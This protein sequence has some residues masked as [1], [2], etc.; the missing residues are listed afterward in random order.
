MSE[1]KIDIDMNLFKISGKTRK[2]R[3]G[4][5]KEG[6]IKVK[7]PSERKKIETLKKRSI[8]KMIREH[9]EDRYKK[10]FEDKKEEPKLQSDNSFNKDFKEAQNFFQ[11]LSEKKAQ[12]VN[13]TV[14]NYTPQSLLMHSNLPPSLNNIN[15]VTNTIHPITTASPPVILQPAFQNITTPVYGCLKHG[16]ILPTYRNLMNQ[17]R[18]TMPTVSVHGTYG[19][20][21]LNLRSEESAQNLQSFGQGSFGGSKLNEHKI[22]ENKINNSIKQ[23]NEMKETAAKLQQ[24]KQNSKPKKI[25][26][27]KTL[28]RT[29]KIGKSKTLPK[30]SVLVSNKTIRN[31]ITTKSQLLKQVP[32]EEVKKFLVKRGLIKIGSITPND[33]LRKMY[34][35]SEMICGE[36]HNHNPDNLMYNFFNE[37]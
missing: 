26:R 21:Q 3:D 5:K 23:V 34:E 12:S 8:L 4:E 10:L 30:V 15:E 29:Y 11:S 19:S 28:R 33:V 18:K 37:K 7:T 35:S 13:K 31:N 2:K 6:G 1:K 32:M 36:V 17:T 16:G 14:R 24:I 25:K 27:K 9:Q 20:Q 22:M